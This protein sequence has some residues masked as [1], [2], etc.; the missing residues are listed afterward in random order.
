MHNCIRKE[1][2]DFSIPEKIQKVE[3][4]PKEKSPWSEYVKE[5]ML[6]KQNLDFRQMCF[7]IN[8]RANRLTDWSTKKVHQNSKNRTIDSPAIGRF[9]SAIRNES[10]ITHPSVPYEPRWSKHRGVQ[11]RQDFVSSHSHFSIN[12]K[13]WK[14]GM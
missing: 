1:K 3:K 13:F 8:H 10:Q 7:S 5:L 4:F 12:G 14:L 2:P 6:A 11:F 9:F